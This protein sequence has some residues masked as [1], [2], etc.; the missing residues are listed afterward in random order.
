[1]DREF[2]MENYRKAK[3][4]FSIRDDK[5]T[6]VVEMMREKKYR[7]VDENKNRKR[8]LLIDRNQIEFSYYEEDEG[9]FGSG[10]DE[11]VS[12]ADLRNM[13]DGVRAVIRG[14]TD[15]FQYNCCRDI[16]RI[17]VSHDVSDDHYTISAGL[18]EVLEREYHIMV[19]N[20]N[21]TFEE[22]IPLL[23]PF[24][25]WEMWFP[26]RDNEPVALER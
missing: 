25:V 23:H 15:S 22:L 16:F 4:I 5:N 6:I 21:L 7:A 17:S 2:N 14:E 1:M 11:Y 3:P 19:T 24:L 9:G 26:V 8:D 18:I 12:T 13:A 10:V 20:P